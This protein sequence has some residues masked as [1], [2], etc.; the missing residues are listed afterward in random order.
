MDLGMVALD[1]GRGLVTGG[2]PL[3]TTLA[4]G[5]EFLGTVSVDIIMEAEADLVICRPRPASPFLVTCGLG[6]ATLR[7]A[8]ADAAVWPTVR[9]T[10]APVVVLLRN[11]SLAEVT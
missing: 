8:V 4:T 11:L 3:L 9:E 2:D 6:E 7:T 5:R 1:T 10:P